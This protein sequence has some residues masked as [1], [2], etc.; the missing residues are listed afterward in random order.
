MA[1]WA[2]K[3]PSNQTPEIIGKTIDYILNPEKTGPELI[4][5]H[6]CAE[7]AKEARRDWI[8]NKRIHRKTDKRQM[9]TALLQSD[10]ACRLQQNGEL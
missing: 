2:I 3:T 1:I 9:Y 8:T 4:Y 7:T 10:N 6:L 5:G